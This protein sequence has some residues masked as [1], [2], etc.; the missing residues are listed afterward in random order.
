MKGY[1]GGDDISLTV[2]T[3]FPCGNRCAFC[4]NREL[5]QGFSLETSDI[6][7]YKLNIM[8]QIEFVLKTYSDVKAVCITG[9]EPFKDDSAA[10]FTME[11]I[12]AIK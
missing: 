2:H 12:N 3:P 11:L 7:S 9:G 8:K 4:T 10:S 1:F 5:Y 6:C